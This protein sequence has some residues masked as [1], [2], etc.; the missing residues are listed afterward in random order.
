MDRDND[1][2]N[3]PAAVTFA[4]RSPIGEVVTNDLKKVLQES[5]DVFN[6]TYAYGIEIT[7]ASTTNT[8]ATITLAEPHSLNSISGIN[9]IAGNN[10]SHTQGTYYNVK[11]LNAANT[12]A[13]DGATANVVVDANGDVTS[14]TIVEGGSGYTDGETL[15]F[16]IADIGGNAYDAGVTINTASINTATDDYIQVT[17]I[18]TISDAYYRITSVPSNV[19]S[20]NQIGVARTTGDPAPRTGQY[21]S[22]IGRV[23]S[24]AVAG[25]QGTVYTLT[26]TK[27]HGLIAGNAITILDSSNNNLGDF[28]VNNL[29]NTNPSTV[30]TVNTTT[31][32]S[33]GAYVLKHGM[34]ANNASAD[35]LG[36]NIGTD[37]RLSMI[38]VFCSQDLVRQYQPVQISLELYFLMAPIQH[39]EFK[40]SSL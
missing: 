5:L 22:V 39:L 14:A 21:V 16:D 12:N 1:L 24:V 34:S 37:F 23:A 33:N 26:S 31:D 3:P 27:G 15:K 11:L 17:G 13:W 18:G 2:D 32:I 35:S 6:K 8:S 10:G 29:D 36:E 38:I 20:N 9:A 4:K 25:P 30:F 28:Y 7:S 19:V 40:K